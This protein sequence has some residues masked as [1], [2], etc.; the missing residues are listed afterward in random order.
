MR[1]DLFSL[2]AVGF[3]LLL[4]HPPFPERAPHQPLK[5]D[6][7]VTVPDLAAERP[8]APVAFGEVLARACAY[9]QAD[10]YPSG[11]AFREAIEAA[12]F[13][14]GERRIPEPSWW[15]KLLK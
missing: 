7:R 5:G 8:D 2:G 12:G 14:T 4:G 15:Q 13:V 3:F 9:D 11:T 1:T 10:R 6:L